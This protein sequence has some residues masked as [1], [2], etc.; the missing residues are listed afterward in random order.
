[1]G[2]KKSALGL[3]YTC[4][5]PLNLTRVRKGMTVMTP[6]TTEFFTGI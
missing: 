6:R 4:G 1:M 5:L 2:D 3:G